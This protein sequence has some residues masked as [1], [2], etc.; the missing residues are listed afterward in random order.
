MENNIFLNKKLYKKAKAKA[1]K[2]Y[3]RHSAYKSMFL[4]NEYKKLGGKFK[5]KKPSGGVNRWNRERWIQVIPYLKTGKQIPCGAQN[6]KNKVCRPLYRI[7]ANT[8]VTLPELLKMGHSK[9]DLLRL[10]NKKVKDMGG[11]VYWARLKFYPSKKK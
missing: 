3:K 8:P 5:N 11:R 4:V 1:D 2:V 9:K 7:S 6:K 10:A